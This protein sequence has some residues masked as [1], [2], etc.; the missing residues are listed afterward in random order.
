MLGF[1]IAVVAGVLTPSIEEALARPLAK[2]LRATLPV[3]SHEMRAL[4]FMI[5]MLGAGLLAAALDSG[6][7]LGVMVGG[8]LGYFGTRIVAAVRTLMDPPRR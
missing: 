5:A 3:D 8:V 4:A 1:L 6:S 7:A 2:T